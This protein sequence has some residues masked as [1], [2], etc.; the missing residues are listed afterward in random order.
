MPGLPGLLED[1]TTGLASS[2]V[3]SANNRSRSIG[4][5]GVRGW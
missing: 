5:G 1:G 2:L 4:V 3:L